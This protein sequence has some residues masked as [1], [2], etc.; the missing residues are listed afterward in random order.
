MSAYNVFLAA[1]KDS[2]SLA[3]AQAKAQVE[4]AFSKA[5]P[6]AAV[7][8]TQADEEYRAS[9]GAAGGWDAWTTHVACGVDFEFRTPLFNA[10]VCTDEVVGRATAQIVEKALANRKMVA[11]I[12]GPGTIRRVVGIDE[13]D[14]ENWKAGW[15]VRLQA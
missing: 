2:D 7:T 15:R 13:V 3:V 10:V 8:V 9:F 14:G 12:M 5:A 4:A 6:H 11:C 1:P